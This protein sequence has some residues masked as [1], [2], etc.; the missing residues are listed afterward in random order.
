MFGGVSERTNLTR[1]DSAAIFGT[2]LALRAADADLVEFGTTHKS[3]RFRRGDSVL[4]VL[5]RFGS[6][7][8]TNTTAAVRAHYRRHD[9]VVIVTD[10]QYTHHRDGGPTAQV[11]SHV[12]V[13]TWNLAGYQVGHGPSGGPGRHTFGGLSDAAF[14]LIP[15]LESGH[16]TGWPWEH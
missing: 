6:L 2:A 13:Y 4:R 11:P 12:P 16:S 10:E 1:A 5:E 9:R 14:R 3:V 7:G 15:L 8:G